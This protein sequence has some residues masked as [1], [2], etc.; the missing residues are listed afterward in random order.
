MSNNPVA[1]S[2][3]GNIVANNSALDTVSAHCPL[4]FRIK[5]F[6]NAH[7]QKT[8]RALS[9]VMRGYGFTCESV[10]DAAHGRR[11]MLFVYANR[12]ERKACFDFI[13]AH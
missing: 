6:D 11:Y 8:Q 1:V 2:R 5:S 10:F 9:D 3:C 7:S 4:A 12:E 13:R